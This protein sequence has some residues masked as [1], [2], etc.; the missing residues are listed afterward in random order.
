MIQWIQFAPTALSSPSGAV[1]ATN[2]GTGRP[3]ERKSL[4]FRL[5]RKAEIEVSPESR[6]RFKAKV[7]APWRVNQPRASNQLRDACQSKVESSGSEQSRKF[8]F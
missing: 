2:S 6:Q 7:R 1:H 5:T 8:R 4:G 3:W